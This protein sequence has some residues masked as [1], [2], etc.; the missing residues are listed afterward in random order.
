MGRPLDTEQVLKVPHIRQRSVLL[1]HHCSCRWHTENPPNTVS[2]GPSPADMFRSKPGHFP[3]HTACPHNIAGRCNRSGPAPRSPHTLRATERRI[4]G[5]SDS[6]SD[7]TWA[8]R[9]I[10]SSAP[11]IFI[12]HLVDAYN[13]EDTKFP[14]TGDP[15]KGPIVRKRPHSK[16]SNLESI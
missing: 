5:D 2:Q 10:K 3:C 14:I 7:V 16:T 11:E 13:D 15:R 6:G 9:C 8:A 4:L 1:G 12:Q